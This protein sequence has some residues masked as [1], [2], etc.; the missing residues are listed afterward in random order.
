MVKGSKYILKD[1]TIRGY[2]SRCSKYYPLSEL[3][4]RKG[5]YFCPKHNSQVR[6]KRR[7][8][9]ESKVARY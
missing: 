5:R 7:K 1:K 2:C 8:R 9:D 3:E 6:L 4:C